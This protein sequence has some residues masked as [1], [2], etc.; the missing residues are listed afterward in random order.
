M[1][2]VIIDPSWYRSSPGSA[3]SR[4]RL[5]LR[6]LVGKVARKKRVFRR[7]SIV[8]PAEHIIFMHDLIA[9]SG[10]LTL[11]AADHLIRRRKHLQHVGNGASADW[12]R[13]GDRASGRTSRYCCYL[14]LFE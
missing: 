11:A 7:K 3:S 12:I 9:V 10:G 4:I 5:Q 2:L 6:S 14:V 1:R 8:E 13:R